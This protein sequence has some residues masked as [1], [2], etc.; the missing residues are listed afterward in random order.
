VDLVPC[1]D[2][3]ESPGSLVASK[4]LEI[5]GPVEDIEKQEADREKRLVDRRPGSLLDV[6]EV[7]QIPVDVLLV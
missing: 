4:P 5:P 3:G 1:E 7:D 6:L 2:D